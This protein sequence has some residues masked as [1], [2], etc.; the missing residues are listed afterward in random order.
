[1]ST[2]LSGGLT[3]ANAYALSA[4]ERARAAKIWN[5]QGRD[6]FIVVRSAE[7]APATAE[8]VRGLHP[9]DLPAP[10]PKG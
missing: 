3:V 9:A 4:A 1:M 10:S 6:G 7:G 2:N 5:R 8:S